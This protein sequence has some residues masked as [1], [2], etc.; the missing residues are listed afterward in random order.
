MFIVYTHTTSLVASEDSFE[1]LLG[2]LTEIATKNKLNIDQTPGIVSIIS[3]EELRQMGISHFDR[4]ALNMIPGISLL[5]SRKSDDYT[6]YLFQINGIS[7]NTEVTGIGYLPMISTKSIQRIEIIRGASSALYGTSAYIA[8]INIVTVQEQNSVWIDY[9]NYSSSNHDKAIGALMYHKIDSVDV[10]LRLHGIDAD[11]IDQSVTQD[12]ASL[13]GLPTNTPS[14]VNKSKKGYDIGLNLKYENWKLD[15]ERIYTGNTAAYGASYIYLPKDSDKIIFAET[16]D[17]LQINHENTID[18]LKINTHIGYFHF[19]QNVEDMYLLPAGIFPTDYTAGVKT[20]EQDLYAGVELNQQFGEH[21][22]LVGMRYFYSN[23]YAE[24]FFATFDFR[25]GTIHDTPSDVGGDIPQTTRRTKSLYIQ[26]YYSFS[27]NTNCIANLRYDHVSDIEQGIIS[28]RL[29]VVHNFNDNNILKMQYAKAYLIPQ[30]YPLYSNPE[31]TFIK[32]NPDL[33]IDEADTYELSYIH[34]KLSH[35]FKSTIYYV[36]MYKIASVI[37]DGDT[38]L[39]AKNSKKSAGTEIEYNHKFDFLELKTNLTY[40]FYSNLKYND[41]MFYDNEILRLPDLLGNVIL[42]K[43]ITSKFSTLFWYNYIGEQ[44][45]Y[46]SDIKTDAKHLINLNFTYLTKLYE[47]SLSI[48]LSA[49]DILNQKDSETPL[50]ESFK[51]DE[52]A[53][54]SR[55]YMMQLSYLF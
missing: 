42:K 2:E 15:Y 41:G 25:D 48:T 30:F 6:K 4:N 44:K 5:S 47:N 1:S 40:N 21:E 29:A 49:N 46:N 19:D 8:L 18:D 20:K 36:N 32:G 34:K 52:Y 38:T 9:T 43:N 53:D 13:S 33:E 23:L 10:S 39:D 37:I 35:S 45:Q 54:N 27:D 50:A 11:G 22:L 28:P 16:K 24:D 14:K 31:T 26:D 17:I 12:S 51:I 3:G 55:R 7:L